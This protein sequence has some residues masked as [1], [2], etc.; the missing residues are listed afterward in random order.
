MDFEQA[1]FN[2][3]EQQIR[4]WEVLD[5]KVLQLLFHVKRENFVTTEQRALAFTDTELPLANG[6][7]MLQPKQEARMVQ[8]LELTNSDTVLE[9]G[10]GSGFVTA[11]L[12]KL[13]G[14]VFSMDIDAQQLMQAKQ[15]LA[16][17]GV[18]NA[19]LVNDDGLNGLQNHAPFNA[20]FVGGSLSVV[21]EILKNQ[22][23]IGGRMIVAVGDQPVMSVQLI[24]R[25]TEHAFSQTTLYETCID[26]L[27]GFERIEP[28]RF[29]F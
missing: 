12:A 9:I 4:P 25:E 22:L 23:A 7:R 27:N 29:I 18:S 17:A 16:T 24:R 3:V 28:N 11:L 5:S 26:R 21:P 1:R 10:T 14:H 19:T 13:A 15:H 20:I 8:D 2:M 6:S